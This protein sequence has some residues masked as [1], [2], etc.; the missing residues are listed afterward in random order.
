MLTLGT[1][2]T[3]TLVYFVRG[4]NRTTG[5]SRKRGRSGACV[6]GDCVYVSS[7][8]SVQ[9]LDDVAASVEASDGHRRAVVREAKC[10]IGGSLVLQY[11]AMVHVSTTVIAGHFQARGRRWESTLGDFRDHRMM[12][13]QVASA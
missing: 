3:E 6:Y 12:G 5:L 13:I 7:P 2:S 8:I 11:W 1:P 9:S 10:P 4:H